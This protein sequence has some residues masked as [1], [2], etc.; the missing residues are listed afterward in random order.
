MNFAVLLLLKVFSVKFGGHGIF[1][2]SKSEQSANFSLRKFYFFTNSLFP[3]KVSAIRYLPNLISNNTVCRCHNVCGGATSWEVRGASLRPYPILTS[4][5]H[6]N[7]R[8]MDSG[9]K[10]KYHLRSKNDRS[11]WNIRRYS[12]AGCK[13]LS[14]QRENNSFQNPQDHNRT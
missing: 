2:R 12:G 8:E 7:K 10:A 3:S 14:H 4:P 13:L 9:Q 1:W 5:P 6:V 11:F